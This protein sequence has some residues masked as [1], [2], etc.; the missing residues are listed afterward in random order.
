MTWF[1]QLDV[2]EMPGDDVECFG[3][4]LNRRLSASLK[5]FWAKKCQNAMVNVSKIF[6]F[7]R[8]VKRK[9]GR[10]DRDE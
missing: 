1:L 10:I 6:F 4:T 8:L 3:N 5:I 7:V 2:S 9:L